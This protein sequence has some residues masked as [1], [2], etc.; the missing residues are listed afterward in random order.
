MLGS[1]SAQTSKQRALAQK[2]KCSSIN[3]CQYILFFCCCWILLCRSSCGNATHLASSIGDEFRS[4]CLVF[5]LFPLNCKQWIMEKRV[6]KFIFFAV[7]ENVGDFRVAW[8]SFDLKFKWNGTWKGSFGIST[9]ATKQ[10]EKKS[11]IIRTRPLK[12]ALH[13]WKLIQIEMVIQIARYKLLW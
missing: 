13:T 11:Q 10:R 9:S 4:V 8:L 7:D 6:Y 2:K 12:L 1:K 5:Y 3:F